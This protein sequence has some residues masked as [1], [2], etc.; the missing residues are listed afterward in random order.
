MNGAPETAS[1]GDTVAAEA[2]SEISGVRAGA[3]VFVGIGVANLGNY[4]FHLLS[5]RTL[6]PSSYGDV[7]TLAA[8]TGI[9][10]LPLGGVQIF[11]ARHVA[12]LAANDRPLNDDTYVSAFSG[13]CLLAGSALTGVLLLLAP[14]IQRALS[15]GSL[16]A[17]VFTVLFTAP[18]FLAPALLGAA[19]GRQRFLLVALGMGAPPVVRIVLV[20]GL[21]AA[22]FGVRGAMAATFLSAVIGVLILLVP[23]RHAL[24]P[25]RAWRPRVSRQDL[26]ALL[27]VVGGLLAITALSS[28]DLVVAKAVFN[29]HQAGI[30][31]S[32]SLIGRVILYLPAAIVT[33]LLPKVS[34]RVAAARDT[35]DILV[36]SL[37]V[38]A[39]FCI[40]AAAIY[41][42]VPHLIVRIAF[43][44]KYAASGP[45]LWMFGISMTLFALLN[46][47]LIYHLG[48]GES[49]TSWLML[50][51]AVVQAALFAVFH[52]TPRELLTTSIVVGATL[53]VAHEAL[54][55]PTLVRLV[56][57]G[58]RP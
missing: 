42:L 36:Q 18:S 8:L 39:A 55:A 28:D 27:P 24:A 44:E 25:A 49:R 40:A 45:L 17:V 14:L 53:L 30:Y 33:V 11:V 34:S 9:V 57:L 35:S 23:L 5:A 15:I 22:G 46:V 51:G 12:A 3:I 4:V 10:A 43:G 19:Q 38:T 6:G 13:A 7:A 26:V 21:L 32:A 37:A 56:G 20:S 52:S 50:G 16:W 2:T 31:G 41:A 1:P 54:V 48:H 47:L 29:S 58:R